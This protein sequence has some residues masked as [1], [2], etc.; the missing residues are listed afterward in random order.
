[1]RHWRYEARVIQIHDS[2]HTAIKQHADLFVS[3]VP[4]IHSGSH[5]SISASITDPRRHIHV[6]N[7]LLLCN[8]KKYMAPGGA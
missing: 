7:V 3:S 6:K 1:M 8:C 2:V 4:P 5:D